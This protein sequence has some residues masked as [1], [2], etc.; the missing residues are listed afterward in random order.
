L[1]VAP[2]PS[3]GI[4]TLLKD[5]SNADTIITELE[6]LCFTDVGEVIDLTINED[7]ASNILKV[8]SDNRGTIYVSTR[9]DIS[10]TG[11]FRQALNYTITNVFF[12]ETVLTATCSVYG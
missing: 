7:R 8:D 4:T 10:I 9:P 3:G 1:Y 11:T 6:A 2:Y 5:R 12:N